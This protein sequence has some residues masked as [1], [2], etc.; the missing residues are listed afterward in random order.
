MKDMGGKGETWRTWRGHKGPRVCMQDLK[1]GGEGVMKD[2]V[3]LCRTWRRGHERPGGAMKVPECT[4]RTS[5]VRAGP[6]GTVQD[7]G[8]GARRTQCVH[9]G[10][11]GGGG[12]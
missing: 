11:G 7:L 2:S 5:D 10:P 1:G 3:C 8:R 4:C 12:G 6:R 9:I